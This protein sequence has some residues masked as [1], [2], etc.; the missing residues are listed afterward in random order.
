MPNKKELLLFFLPLLLT[1]I[2]T[3]GY[4]IFG[5]QIDIWFVSYNKQFEPIG[6][7]K[8]TRSIYWICGI[9]SVL[10]ISSLLRPCVEKAIRKL[11]G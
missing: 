8:N 10:F 4:T 5:D 9:W 1:L 2:L 3:I 11:R 7:I 6:E